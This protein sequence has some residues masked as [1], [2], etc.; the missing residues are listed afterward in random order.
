MDSKKP[1]EK[2]LTNE[3][4][5]MK[6]DYSFYSHPVLKFICYLFHLQF[7]ENGTVIR[8]GQT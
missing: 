7:T 5:V 3:L 2:I 8:V 4:I 6:S 1:N